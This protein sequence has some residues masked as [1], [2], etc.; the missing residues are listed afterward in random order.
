[1]QRIILKCELRFPVLVAEWV[2]SQRLSYRAA[3]ERK[4]GERGMKLPARHRPRLGVHHDLSTKWWELQ[5]AQVTV[6]PEVFRSRTGI[7]A[8]MLSEGFDPRQYWHQERVVLKM[9]WNVPAYFCSFTQGICGHICFQKHIALTVFFFFLIL[10]ALFLSQ[11]H[12]SAL[13]SDLTCPV[14]CQHSQDPQDPSSWIAWLQIINRGCSSGMENV[15]M[16]CC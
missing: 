2:K 7:N 5:K 16:F 15:Q 14:D 4:R 10:R 12:I 6:V 3:K 11:R 1:M 13:P 9:V 8:I